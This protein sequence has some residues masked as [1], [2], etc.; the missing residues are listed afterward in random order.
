MTAERLWALAY[1]P[2]TGALRHEIFRGHVQT[3]GYLQDYAMLGDGFMR[4]FE[5]TKK[6]VWRDRAAALATAYSTVSP[7]PTARYRPRR[8]KRGC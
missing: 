7:N 8:I 3:D 1:D 2:K 4:L 6:V 5:T